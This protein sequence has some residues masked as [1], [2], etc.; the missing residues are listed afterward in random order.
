LRTPGI[1]PTAK[2]PNFAKNG[3]TID[4]TV[5]WNYFFF[6]GI[7]AVSV[8]FHPIRIERKKKKKIDCVRGLRQTA[9][10]FIRSET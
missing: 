5:A 3:R 2:L 7:A 6:S 9:V 1:R 4:G 8:L 10:R